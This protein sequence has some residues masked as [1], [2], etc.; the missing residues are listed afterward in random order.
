MDCIYDRL[1]EA[2]TYSGR[3]VGTPWKGGVYMVT[4]EAVNMMFQ[5]GIFLATAAL[6]I[7]AIIALDAKRKK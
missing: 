7:A 6:A 3:T 5:F 1:I 4:F 2:T